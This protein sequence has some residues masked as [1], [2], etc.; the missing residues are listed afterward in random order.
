M[1][2]HVIEGLD[3]LARRAFTADDVR[4]MVEAGIMAE[5]EPVELVEGELIAMAGKGIAH[6][7]VKGDITR[8]LNRVLEDGI[9]V[10]N[11]T[12]LRLNELTLVEPDILV[13]PRN[14]IERSPEGF[15]TAQGPRIL[16]VIE[17]ANTSL[18][19]DRGRKATIY[20]RHG[21]SEYWVIDTDDRTTHVHSTPRD[22]AYAS[23]TSV[24]AETL[25]TPKTP[26]LSRFSVRMTEIG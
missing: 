3:G 14:A 2:V 26:E 22:A 21:V 25:L 1:T 15:I 11:E 16:L 12:T 7:L 19:Y 18:A 23:I 8:R 9:F 4:R 6:E 13:L 10:G 17:V 5:N 20:G 24:A